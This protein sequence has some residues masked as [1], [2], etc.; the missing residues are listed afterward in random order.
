MGVVMRSGRIIVI[1]AALALF[2]SKAGCIMY[3]T[4]GTDSYGKGLSYPGYKDPPTV[5][6]FVAGDH[7]SQLAPV[8]LRATIYRPEFANISS[9]NRSYYER[10]MGPKWHFNREPVSLGYPALQELD[11]PYDSYVPSVR[12]FVRS[13]WMP[14]TVNYQTSALQRFMESDPRHKAR[15][16]AFGFL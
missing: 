10:L 15:E 11:R 2:A 16:D 1:V 8:F 4:S 6:S 13:D 5:T 3:L 7:T 14:G 12:E 9:I